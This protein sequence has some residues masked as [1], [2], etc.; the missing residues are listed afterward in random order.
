MDRID[1]TNGDYYIGPANKNGE[2]HGLGTMYYHNGGR[3]EGQWANGKKHGYGT[4]YCN[5]NS[6][7]TAEGD[8]FEGEWKDDAKHGRFIVYK[9]NG[10]TWEGKYSLDVPKAGAMCSPANV[11]LAFSVKRLCRMC[12]TAFTSEKCD[13]D[14][15]FVHS[16]YCQNC[17]KGKANWREKNCKEVKWATG[18]YRKCEVAK[19]GTAT[20]CGFCSWASGD[21]YEGDFKNGVL[22]G[23]GAY[24]SANGNFYEGDYKDGK[25]HGF[26][27]W[28][29]KEGKI[30][31]SGEWREGV[32]IPVD[33]EKIRAAQRTA[34]EQKIT[35]KRLAEEEK[36]AYKE[37]AKKAKAQ[38]CTNC[39]EKLGGSDWDYAL[40]M[41]HPHC[42]ACKTVCVKKG[43]RWHIA[44]CG[45]CGT[46]I[47]HS[48]GTDRGMC[49]VCRRVNKW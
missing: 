47:R 24:Y 2:P 49:P 39:G 4:F 36:K 35:D 48:Y 40:K 33:E 7:H 31:A 38:E 18:D 5:A 43:G 1:F 34:E 22:H 21:Y 14:W 28:Y 41:G 16:F 11:T 9:S 32:H 19:D 17:A 8:R 42:P 15:R 27:T 6:V 29:G 12:G 3:Y 13:S 20:G 46:P 37:A 45:E 10:A 25:R 26:G 23:R 30:I 44:A